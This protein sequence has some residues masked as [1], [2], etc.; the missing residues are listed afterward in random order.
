MD[1]PLNY[2]EF[3]STLKNSNPME[4]WPQ[5]LKA[6]WYDAKGDWQ[7][8]HEIVDGMK[9]AIGKWIHAYLHRKEGDEWNAGYWYLQAGRSFPVISLH[10]EHQEIVETI[11]ANQN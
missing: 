5:T 11:L 1:I 8:A 2:S 10:K 7:A 4:D 9:D 6:L 3:T